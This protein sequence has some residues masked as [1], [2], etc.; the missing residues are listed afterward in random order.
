M[1]GACSTYGGKKC[2]Y[3]VLVGKY[4]I[5]ILSGRQRHNWW[6]NIKMDHQEIK[7]GSRGLESSVSG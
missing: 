5:K 3:R 2:A 4:E 1:G 6:H 7:M